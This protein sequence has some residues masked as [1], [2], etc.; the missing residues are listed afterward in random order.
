MIQF[1]KIRHLLFLAAL[2]FA[3]CCNQALSDEIDFE[4]AIAPI[5]ES[6]CLECHNSKSRKGG[7]N[8]ETREDFSKGGE[9][10][11]P[12]IVSGDS[13]KSLL[14]EKIESGEMP[15]KV[16]GKAREL[17]KVEIDLIRSWIDH[18]AKW[19]KNR[20]LQNL[21]Q[22]GK[23]KDALN[24][25]SFQE[26]K[27]PKIPSVDSKARP[28]ISNAIDAFVLKKLLDNGLEMAPKADS[29]QFLRRIYYDTIGLPPTL[30]QV[31]AFEID[32][33]SNA[34]EKQVETLLANPAF[35]EK[36]SRYWL[37]V[38]RFAETNG[39]ER[40]AE[41]KH[42]W[43][44]RD[45]VIDGLNS[46]KPFDQ[47]L[48]HQLAGDEVSNANSES[49]T[50]TGMLRV[51]T[52]DDEPNDQKE[53]IYERLDDLVHVT[54]TAFLALTVKC[55]RCHDHKFDPV[56]QTD[57]YSM[58]SVFWP[59]YIEPRDS[60]FMGGPTAK[61]L[62]FDLLGWTDRSPNP[63]PIYLLAK[64]DPERPMQEVKPQHLAIAPKLRDFYSVAPQGSKTSRRRLQLAKWMVNPKNP[65]TARVAVNRIWQRYFGQG[66]VANHQ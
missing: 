51:G 44:Y 15:P 49:V 4:K 65:L 21:E 11:E 20:R 31:A 24:W 62:G 61:E 46:D 39:Y 45:W 27:R 2:A 3:N 40:D 42:A 43:K 48:I 18:G 53:Y 32:D 38:V 16:N 33:S 14:I 23:S 26:I 59:G 8:L 35:G 57:Y 22:S 1:S 10:E 47:F 28:R 25:W 9:S 58:A 5:F 50:G 13:K 17:S 52:W 41:K 54:S 6:S 55:A 36:W 12:A 19:P 64:G 63:K 56:P 60:K 7:L 30:N 66:I 37:D 29:A 34:I